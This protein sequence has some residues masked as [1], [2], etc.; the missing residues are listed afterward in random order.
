MSGNASSPSESKRIVCVD[1]LRGYAIFGMLIVNAKAL[2]FEPVQSYF[3]GSS[4]QGLY[5]AILYQ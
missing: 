2:F 3:A 4:F 1:Q 5:D